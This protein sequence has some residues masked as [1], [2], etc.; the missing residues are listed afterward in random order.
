METPFA[1]RYATL[2]EPERNHSSSW[3]IDFRCT[4]LVVT[5]GKPS[6]SGKRICQPNTDSV[7]VPVRSDLRVPCSSTWRIRS[8]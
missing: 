3:T 5:S 7:P 1:F 8:R 6:A 4:F 2:V